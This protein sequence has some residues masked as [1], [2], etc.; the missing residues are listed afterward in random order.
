[1]DADTSWPHTNP[2]N[3]T[4]RPGGVPSFLPHLV[5]PLL[6]ALAFLPMERKRIL[7]WSPI[8]WA[9]DLDFFFAKDYHRAALSNIW[10][11]LI[12]IGVLVWLWR[13]RDPEASIL[14][15]MFRPGA[16]G[17]L[18]LVSYYLLSHILM[19]IFAGGVSLLWPLMDT[20]FYLF[21]QILVN[22]E[23]NQPEATGG[24]GAEPGIVE[25]TPVFE[26]LS[27][28]DTAVGVFLI[29]AT[30]AWLGYRTWKRRVSPPPV[31]VMREAERAD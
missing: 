9:P 17:A 10:I 31:I 4:R 12:V 21:Y 19:D 1:M 29:A 30:A 16:P 26:W 7:A 22:T 6:F 27:P 11:P 8:V 28:I 5:A 15:F 2:I 25:I 18:L 20:N 24:G 14:E 3:P 13:R 23:T